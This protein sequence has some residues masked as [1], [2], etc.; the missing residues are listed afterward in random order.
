VTGEPQPTG[1]LCLRCRALPEP[2]G[3]TELRAG[4]SRGAW[5][6]T[7]DW[8]RLASEDRNSKPETNSTAAGY[9]AS[10]EVGWTASEK[11]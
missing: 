1:E 4:G 2:L 5:K 8:A 9:L 11:R 3:E 6:L 10:L 7:R